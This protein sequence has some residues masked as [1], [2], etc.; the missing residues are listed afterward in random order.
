MYIGIPFFFG[1]GIYYKIQNS[2]QITNPEEA[3]LQTGNIWGR[4]EN[5]D[6]NDDEEIVV[7]YDADIEEEGEGY[8]AF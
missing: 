1:I 5:G 7:D 8:Q 2:T 4:N 6:E 3:D